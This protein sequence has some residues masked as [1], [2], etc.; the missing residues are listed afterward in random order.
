MSYS[1]AEPP[2]SLLLLYYAHELAHAHLAQ[3]AFALLDVDV[4]DKS[5]CEYT[6]STHSM[7]MSSNRMSTTRPRI[8]R[9]CGV[10]C[11][12]CARSC[13]VRAELVQ[14]QGRQA[15]ADDIAEGWQG[16][17]DHARGAGQPARRRTQPACLPAALVPVPTYLYSFNT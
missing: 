4:V 6:Y 3:P 17:H 13:A 16:E 1:G 15:G 9:Y 10:R 12:H 14:A 8:S 7:S 11:L 2:Y 5:T